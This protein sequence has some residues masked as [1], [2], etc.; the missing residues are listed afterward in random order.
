MRVKMDYGQVAFKLKVC[1]RGK[2]T[3]EASSR[4]PISTL[5]TMPTSCFR[6][7]DHAGTSSN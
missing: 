3:R 6:P 4:S 5:R 7:L 1:Y 2:E